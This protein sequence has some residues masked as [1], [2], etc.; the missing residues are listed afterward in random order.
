MRL[1]ALGYYLASIPALLQ[2]VKNWSAF[3]ALAARRPT[4]VELRRPALRFHARS[5]MDLWII[6]ETCLDRDYE[7]IGEELQDGWIV[8]DIGAG[9]GDFTI[10]A[11]K[12]GPHSRIYAYEPFPESYA[13]LQENL[14]LNAVDNVQSFPYAVSDGRSARLALA[15]HGEAVQHRAALASS[16][17]AATVDVPCTSLD[18][19]LSDA[20]L[21]RCD[22]LKIDVEGAEY[23]ILLGASDEAL[24]AFRRVCLEY[25]DGVTPYSHADLVRFLQDKG[26]QVRTHSNPVHGHLGLLYAWR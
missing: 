5:L 20:G 23:S 12:S 4:V 21:S 11:A 14:K 24:S 2:G 17:V 18:R 9:L 1:S 3:P 6:K 15:L 22:F 8:L 25:H 10:Y 7:R 16:P 26:Y 19:V 13:L